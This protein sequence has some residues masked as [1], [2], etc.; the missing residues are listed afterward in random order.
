MNIEDERN[1][2]DGGNNEDGGINKSGSVTFVPVR[3][4]VLPQSLN[5][6]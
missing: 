2:E 6:P 4:P 1:H 3:A 5:T